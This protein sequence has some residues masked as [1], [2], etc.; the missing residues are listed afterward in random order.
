VQALPTHAVSLYV[1]PAVLVGT[2]TLPVTDADLRGASA[3]TL[4]APASLSLVRETLTAWAFAL[5][6]PVFFTVNLTVKVAPARAS[7]ALRE[8]FESFSAGVVAAPATSAPRRANSAESSQ[9]AA[10]R[11]RLA[12]MQVISEGLLAVSK[13]SGRGDC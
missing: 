8:S 6:L 4:T 9:M 1:P 12:S 3:L 7:P 13:R 11:P 5:R 2:V 10:L